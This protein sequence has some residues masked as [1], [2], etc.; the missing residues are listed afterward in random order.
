MRIISGNSAIFDLADLM[1]HTKYRNCSSS[2]K[3]IKYLWKALH[4]M[5]SDSKILFLRFCTSCS[6]APIA[7]FVDLVPNFTIDLVYIANDSEKLP[8]AQ[9]CFNLLHLPTYSSY[10][11]TKAKLELAIS[12]GTGFYLA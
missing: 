8:S 5:A 9:T 1:K 4:H 10:E 6:R 11:V 12:A 2:D 3:H 7:G